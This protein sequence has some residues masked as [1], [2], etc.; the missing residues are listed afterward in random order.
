M[1]MW[2][3]IFFFNNQLT[4]P[5]PNIAQLILLSLQHIT[6]WY[7]IKELTIN[8]VADI[9]MAWFHTWQFGYATHYISPLINSCCANQLIRILRKPLIYKSKMRNDITRKRIMGQ[10]LNQLATMD[11]AM[12][13]TEDFR[14]AWVLTCEW[15]MSITTACLLGH[16]IY[17]QG[18]SLHSP[19]IGIFHHITSMNVL[20]SV[21]NTAV[22][23]QTLQLWKGHSRV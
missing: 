18:S 11:N 19:S 12:Q 7:T 15:Y 5:K 16:N 13:W 3:E 23:G 21:I 10:N 2:S 1:F 14:L 4:G 17:K 6:T 20:Q 8:E 9:S 22:K